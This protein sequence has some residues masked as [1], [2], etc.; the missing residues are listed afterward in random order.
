MIT[1]QASHITTLSPL[2]ISQMIYRKDVTPFNSK[3]KQ[4]VYYTLKLNCCQQ[5]WG[6]YNRVEQE[7]DAEIWKLATMKCDHKL[8]LASTLIIDHALR[9][10]KAC[11]VNM[12]LN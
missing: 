5:R 4:L 10:A 8:L 12:S 1:T 3:N 2:Q 7:A 6:T 9:Q 11:K